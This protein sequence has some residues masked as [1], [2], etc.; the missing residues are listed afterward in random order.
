MRKL[1]LLIPIAMLTLL[2][3]SGH[4]QTPLD[5]AQ[6]LLGGGNNNRDQDAYQRGREDE[7]RH[8]RAEHRHAEERYDSRDR[9]RSYDDR[10]ARSHDGDRD[11]N[12]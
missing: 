5:R 4:A 10:S 11:R 8:Q 7:E 3:T 12:D 6:Q 9:S 1:T 2:G